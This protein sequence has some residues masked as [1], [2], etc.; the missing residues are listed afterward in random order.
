M[1]NSA[2]P[3][4]D[5]HDDSEGQNRR[6]AGNVRRTAWRIALIVLAIFAGI[7]LAKGFQNAMINSQD[8]QWSPARLLLEGINPYQVSL[9]GNMNGLLLLTQEPNYLHLLY[10]LFLPLGFLD[11]N[12]VKPVWALANVL[13]GF[14]SAYLIARSGTRLSWD[15]FLAILLLF[16]CSTP[17][18]NT[19]SNGQHALLILM[20]S[21]L[22]W[23]RRASL[24]SAPLFSISYVKYSF[25]PPVVFWLLLEKRFRVV[26]ASFIV[27]GL[28]WMLFSVL[29]GGDPLRIIFQPLQVSAKGVGIGT[30]DIMSISKA[31]DLDQYLV[32]GI[33][34]ASGLL[35]AALLALYLFFCCRHLADDDVF[36]ALGL[37]SLLSF[38]HLAYDF[39]FLLPLACRALSLELWRRLVVLSG[40]GYF[41]FLLR[42]FMTGQPN[43]PV[44]VPVNFLILL[45][46]FFAFTFS[47]KGFM[48]LP[49]HLKAA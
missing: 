29:V 18:R 42:I 33:G 12:T 38:F 49:R 27:L 11:W 1:K 8:F 39:V 36:V 28:A 10:I 48:N 14:F 22:A 17:L 5:Q 20:F 46:M 19:I 13:L 2:I 41:W 32:R 3:L 15:A 35:L 45:V 21:Y 4:G 47:R 7:S 6:D 34:Y 30:A 23:S 44:L 40:I 26:A 16:F 24:I 31:F 37:I 9:E 43:Y 25:A